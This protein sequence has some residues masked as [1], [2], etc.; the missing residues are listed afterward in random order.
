M[1]KS[2]RISAAALA[3]PVID[4][5]AERPPPPGR[6]T[7]AEADLWRRLVHSRRPQW[8]AGAEE[9]LESYIV[10][11]IALQAVEAELRKTPPSAGARYPR[12][13]RIH[14]QQVSLCAMLA[15]K[16]RLV[17]STRRDK[18]TPSEGDRP[19]VDPV[20]PWADWRGLQALPSNSND[21]DERCF[22][23]LRA[24]RGLGPVVDLRQDNRAN[25]LQPV[26]KSPAGAENAEKPSNAN[27]PVTAIQQEGNDRGYR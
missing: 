5:K 24:V 27:M 17:P 9:I 2:G 11:A 26:P 6:L 8:F 16:L 12:C 20:Y 18:N 1:R 14:R 25:T 3:T 21:T 19:M 7:P 15:T 13:L 23:D 10:A 4:V 22:A